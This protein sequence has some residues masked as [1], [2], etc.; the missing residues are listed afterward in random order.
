MVLLKNRDIVSKNIHT[1]TNWKSCVLTAWHLLYTWVDLCT[2][3]MVSGLELVES[4]EC[5][6]ALDGHLVCLFS[7]LYIGDAR[8]RSMCDSDSDSRLSQKSYSNSDSDSNQFLLIPLRFQPKI[9]DSDSTSR[10]EITDS[11][12]NSGSILFRYSWFWFQQKW[13]HSGI[14]IVH[15]CFT[16][17]SLLAI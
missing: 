16:C 6:Q 2:R 13:N 7:R 10:D 17:I 14:V 15:R 8:F 9:L 4:H 3:G 1:V 11:N 12:S 5:H